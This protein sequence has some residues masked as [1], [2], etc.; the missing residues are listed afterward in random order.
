MIEEEI[1]WM[2]CNVGQIFVKYSPFF[3]IY[4]TF[5][6]DFDASNQKIEDLNQRSVKFA[7][8]LEVT[9]DRI[10][11]ELSSILITVVQRIPRYELLFRDLLKRTEED[12][13]DYAS[14]AKALNKINEQ[15]SFI[16]EKKRHYENQVFYVRLQQ[17]LLQNH[18]H[19]SQLVQPGRVYMKQM[20][21]VIVSCR[22]RDLNHVRDRKSVV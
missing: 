4:A 7:R 18:H 6:N 22:R 21:Q 15:A 13:V 10:Q 17:N 5:V 11:K 14:I 1:C 20:Q 2:Y 12:H 16:N 9:S 3:K 8:F 19:Y